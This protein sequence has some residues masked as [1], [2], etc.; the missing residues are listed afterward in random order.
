MSDKSLHFLIE[1]GRRIL[2]AAIN[3]ILSETKLPAFLIEG[4]LLDVLCDIRE[5][6]AMELYA[7]FESTKGNVSNE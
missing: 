5:Q 3:Q 6:K 4:I 2:K 7:E 1:K